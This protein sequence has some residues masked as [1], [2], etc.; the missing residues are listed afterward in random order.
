MCFESNSFFRSKAVKKMS[1]GHKKNCIAHSM[2]YYAQLVWKLHEHSNTRDH[3]CQKCK[4][5]RA[6][7]GH[8]LLVQCHAIFICRWLLLLLLSSVHR[9]GWDYSCSFFVPKM[10]ICY[11]FHIWHTCITN[12]ACALNYVAHWMYAKSKLNGN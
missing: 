2:C 12:V 7:F 3:D 6:Y 5:K 10:V 11:R 1:G 9:K 8:S 4:I